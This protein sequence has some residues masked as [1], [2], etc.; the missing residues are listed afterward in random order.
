MATTPAVLIEAKFAE[1]AQTTQYTSTL[2]QTAIDK[3][4]GT[5]VT[6]LAATI[7]VNLVAPAGTAVAGNTITFSK[8]IPAGKTYIFPEI[9]AHML[10]IGG[11][12]STIAGTVNAIVIRA[13]GR[14]FT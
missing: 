6:G 10:E 7:S 8:T 2:A 13:S 4:T 14:K 11:S 12:I 9:V 1:T 5:N 3:F